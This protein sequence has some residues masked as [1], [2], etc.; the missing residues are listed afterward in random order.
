MKK[1]MWTAFIA[2]L[3]VVMIAGCAQKTPENT[4]SAGASEKNTYEIVL[5]ENQPDDYPTTIG[6]K[7]FAE[8]VEE[9]SDGRI[10]VDVFSGGQLG[11]ERSALEQVQIGSIEMTRT[12]ASPLV[13]FSEDIGVLSM[14]YLFENEEAMWDVLLSDIGTDLLNSLED[15]G[16]Q[17]LAFYDSGSRHL[18]NT[19]RPIEEPEDMK[20]L[21]IRVQ[22][23]NMMIDLIDTLG[24][25]PSTMSFSEVYSGLETGVV[26][27]AE[28]N[29]PSFYTT[30]HY[31]VADY[32]TLNAHSTVP[33]VLIMSDDFWNELS[34]EDQEIV[35]SAAQ[36]SIEIQREAWA[37]LEE[38]AA[39]ALEENGNE[40]IEI[41]D[42]SSWR[43][44]VQPLYEKYGPKYEDWIDRIDEAQ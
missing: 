43:E 8:M 27:G 39:A 38:E 37:E 44:A 16:M 26:D 25:S 40:V 32:Y 11:D 31:E 15:A 30:N 4:D 17:G 34:E 3:V 36:D 21:K 33:E 2:S 18:Y 41:N 29:L 9:R 42:Y 24:G 19:E 14:P 6:D 5:A 20:D 28:N 10:Q 1:F 35:W 13:D 7:A 22:P 23:S 12:N